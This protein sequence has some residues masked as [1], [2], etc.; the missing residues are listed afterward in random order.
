VAAF[1]VLTPL[2]DWV[3]GNTYLF[4]HY[5]PPGVVLVL[6][7]LALV[8]NPLL[9]K[10]RLRAGEAVVVIA[11]LMALGGVASNGFSRLWTQIAS[12]PARII[13]R[14]P[15]LETLAPPGEPVKLPPGFFVGLPADAPLDTNDPEY[16]LVIDGFYDGLA[17][18][19][20]VEHRA[21]VT[22]RDAGG[23]ERQQLA[24]GGR[25]ARSWAPGTF[26]D[27]DSE[28]GRSLQS[29]HA[30]D[31]VTTPS[32]VFTVVAVQS[33]TLPAHA[34]WPVF[35]RWSPLLGG[36]LLASLAI[37][38]LVR[39]QW[40]QNERLP[41]PI[42]EF[43]YGF[44]EDPAPGRRLPPLL[45]E[46]G[47]WYGAAIAVFILGTQGLEAMG[48][49]PMSVKTS[50]SFVALGNNAWVWNMYRPW[51][52]LNPHVYLS[53][54][55][56]TFFLPT[57]LS[58]SLWF[59]FIAT[60]IGFA[61]ARSAGVPLQYEDA[62]TAAIGGYAVQAL[63]ILFIGRRY[64]L[65]LL[66]AAFTRSGDQ[67]TRMLVPYVWALLLGMAAMAGTMVAAGARIDHALLAV[68][69]LLGLVLVLARLVAEAGIAFAQIPTGWFV[70]QIV[71][72]VTGFALP[73][74]SLAPLMLLGAGLFSDSR[75]HIL[76]YAV[77]VEHLAGKAAVPRRRLSL[78]MFIVACAGAAACVA[79]MVKIYYSYQHGHDSWP[80]DTLLAHNLQP[81]SNGAGGHGADQAHTWI[82]YGIGGALLALVGIGRLMFAWWPLHPLGLLV[83]P[84]YAT[85]TIW[86]SFLVGWLAKTMV[87]RYGGMM[88]YKRL[89]PF[90]AGLIAGEASMTVLFLF[91]GLVRW[92]MSMPTTGLPRFLPG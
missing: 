10:R 66:R 23:T 20:R 72:S 63:L 41:F 14:T 51:E 55:A 21:V 16:R 84:A 29:R 79:I 32:G 11:M 40:S 71:F 91:V 42:A 70:S 83:V 80:H 73:L 65:A 45:C 34:W 53:I 24:L 48:L 2:N 75:E 64:Y 60:Q 81:L 36:M 89:K 90:A 59:F 74:A 28:P 69:V 62:A 46:R 50:F 76:P 3:I 19:G 13:P 8:V 57:G 68:I 85:W 61:M 54:V 77:Q 31:V 92:L 39:D 9:G 15:G 49:L 52:L 22:W 17:S 58:F 67:R 33:P 87:M 82:A 47:F 38:A 7:A 44:I 26:L 56:L 78:T 37:A 88:L 6:F 27:L 35:L 30:G 4:S 5:L 12:G 86:A 1:A 43:L 18:S 25:I